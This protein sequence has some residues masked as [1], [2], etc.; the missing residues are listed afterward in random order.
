LSCPVTFSYRSDEVAAQA[1]SGA[2]RY[3]ITYDPAKGR[4]YLDAS[5]KMPKVATPS[6]DGLRGHRVLGVD[7]N[8]SHLAAIVV[9]PSGNP[10]GVPTTLGICL[11]GLS[12]TTRDGHLRA[13]ISELIRRAKENG[14]RAIVIEDLDFND[15]RDVGRERSGR[16]PSRGKRGRSY[17]R[18]VAGMPTA[19][20]ASRLNQMAANAGLSVI[21]VDP[22][23]TSMWGTEHWLGA[24]KEISRESNGHHAAALVIGRR[25]LAQ[26]ARRRV[27][28]DSTPAAHGEERATDSVVQPISASAGLRE[29]RADRDQENR[30]ARGQPPKSGRQ[31]SQ[32]AKPGP[33]L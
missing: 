25:G 8:A 5:W 21:A 24:L 16:R 32:R 19:K 11:A 4:W 2:V 10:A 1:A 27:R 22:A 12:T 17:R 29:P 26:R 23:Y 6:L 31:R 9:D 20:F 30:K 7:H 3:D 14:C 18:L 28:C 13:V 15:A 33:L